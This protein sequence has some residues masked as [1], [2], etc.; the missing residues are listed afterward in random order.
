MSGRLFSSKK[1]YLPVFILHLFSVAILAIET[2]TPL[3][4][5]AVFNGCDLIFS[6]TCQAGRSHSSQLFAVLERALSD[7]AIPPIDQ[8]AVGLGPGSYAGVRIA[9]SAAVGYGIASGARLTGIPSIATLEGGAYIALGDARRESFYFAVVRDGE[10]VEGPV[11]VSAAGLADKLAGAGELAVYA[12]EPLTAAPQA[13]LRFP[14]AERLGRLA[15]EGKSVV[16]RN[17]LEPIYLRDA[18]ITQPKP[19]CQ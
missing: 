12:S 5:V 15:V 4:S 14:S 16:A 13:Q 3:G 19:R 10:A 9:I 8:I 2:S 1:G 7:P 18:Y 17:F 6:E 11:L